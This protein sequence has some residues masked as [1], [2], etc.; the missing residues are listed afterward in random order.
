MSHEPPKVH[1]TSKHGSENINQK[2]L[3]PPSCGSSILS[4]GTEALHYSGTTFWVRTPQCLDDKLKKVS[5][6]RK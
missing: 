1:V 5:I 4:K 2:E 3:Q 6:I